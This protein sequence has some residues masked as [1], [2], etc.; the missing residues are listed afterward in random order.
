MA[1]VMGTE[2]QDT[3]EAPPVIVSETQRAL[4]A[5]A[6]RAARG[7]TAWRRDTA[8]RKAAFARRAGLDVAPEAVD[9]A[10]ERVIGAGDFLPGS[11]LERG[12]AAADAVALIELASRETATGFLV[13]P[14]LLLTNRHVFPTPDAAAGAIL[15]FRFQADTGSELS[16][17]REHGTDPGRFHLA[18]RADDLDYALVAVAPRPGSGDQP[19]GDAYHVVPM[20]GAIGKALLGQPV[21]LV[22]HPRGRLRELAVRNNLLLTVTEHALTYAAD[23]E[24]GSSGAPVFND[25]WELLALHRRSVEARNEAGEPVDL[26][27]RPVTRTTPEAQRNW[28]A[29]EGIRTSAIVAD[30]RA[31]DLSEAHR[32]LVADI[33]G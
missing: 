13:T 22:Q 19:P 31:R 18:G 7:G 24:S 8:A 14:W 21:N 27:G 4:L 1:R 26:N 16:R 11:W 2:A 6:L 30:I 9:S 25:R 15:R 10:L 33:G 12:G 29:N 20:I 32:L 17:V 5:D 3:I 23:T 28:I